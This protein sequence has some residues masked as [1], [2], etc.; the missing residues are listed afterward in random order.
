MCLHRMSSVTSLKKLLSIDT[1]LQL[2]AGKVAGAYTM[3]HALVMLGMRQ[4]G[5]PEA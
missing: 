1:E 4:T 2:K 3:V 5:T